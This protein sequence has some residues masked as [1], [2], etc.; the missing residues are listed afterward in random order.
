M[1]AAAGSGA[2]VSS[3]DDIAS[4]AENA[5]SA[6]SWAGLCSEEHV[7]SVEQGLCFVAEPGAS[8]GFPRGLEKLVGIVR[9]ISSPQ[10]GAQPE[11]GW[12]FRGGRSVEDR[13]LDSGRTRSVARTTGGRWIWDKARGSVEAEVDGSHWA[14]VGVVIEHDKRSWIMCHGTRASAANKIS[15]EL[16]V[17]E[18]RAK[19]QWGNKINLTFENHRIK[20]IWITYGNRVFDFVLTQVGSPTKIVN[21]L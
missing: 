8:L 18:V 15:S 2:A 17:K 5:W 10:L 20:I 9:A 21:I 12:D 19:G 13:F 6:F 7:I 14:L 11:R 1:S 16:N 3:T 4:A